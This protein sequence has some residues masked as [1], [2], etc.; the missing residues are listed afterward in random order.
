MAIQNSGFQPQFLPKQYENRLRARILQVAKTHLGASYKL[1][2]KALQGG[3]DCSG[4]ITNVLLAALDNKSFN[5]HVQNI[6]ILR[7]TPILQTIENPEPGDLILW[8]SHG[9]IV[10]NPSVGEFI[11]AQTSTGVA[12]ASYTQGYWS[13]QPGLM[14]RKF[15][16]YFFG[17][18]KEFLAD[19]FK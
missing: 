13:K 12:V 15:G 11:G 5:P 9:G 16:S 10:W 4:F 3:I 1:G 14:F 6:V 7:S 17:W 18:S 8:K 19:A 2:G